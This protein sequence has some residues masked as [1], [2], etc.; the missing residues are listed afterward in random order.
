MAVTVSHFKKLRVLLLVQKWAVPP[1]DAT[2]TRAKKA[3]WKTEY[4]VLTALQKVGH[5]V[6]ILGVEGE[7]G[8]I[9]RAVHEWKPHVAFNLMEDFDGVA[10]FDQNVVSYLELLKVPYTGCNPRGLMITKDKAL[11]K[12]ILHYHRIKTPG[13]HVFRRAQKKIRRPK[14][15]HYP[16]IVKS[17]IEE[18]S[19][20]ISQ[21]SVVTDD[22]KLEERVRFIH[23]KIQT[24]ALVESYIEGRE[25]YVGVMGNHQLE[26]LPVWELVFRK[27]PDQMANIATRRVKWN[28]GYRSKYGI[29]SYEARNLDPILVEKIQRIAKRAFRVLNLNGYARFDFRL[30]P[31][32]DV[33]L[34][35]ANPNP[36]IGFE[37]DFAESAET[38]GLNYRDL[39]DRILRLGINWKPTSIV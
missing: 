26:A 38:V 7:L 18:A 6:R 35:E 33:Y 10:I 28:P 30:T 11:C 9:R 2:A 27:A 20:G 3:E 19:L 17:L 21:S 39:M 16:L 31:N 8:P 5:E 1:D 22:K 23:E 24:D 32:G 13:F 12:K 15:L 29:T 36:H 37:E 25:L 14:G 34:L 4:D